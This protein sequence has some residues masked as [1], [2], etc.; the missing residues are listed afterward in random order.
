MKKSKLKE[1]IKNNITIEDLS[2]FVT[3]I[4]PNAMWLNGELCMI[5]L[6]NDGEVVQ[7]Q[8]KVTKDE[9]EFLD[10]PRIDLT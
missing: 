4:F 9:D 8:L 3:E 1:K 6:M 2:E 5:E 10:N 7:V